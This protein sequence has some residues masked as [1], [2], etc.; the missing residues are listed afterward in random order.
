M[1]VQRIT[2]I[3][4]N[5]TINTFG[6]GA[7]G[8]NSHTFHLDATAVS[9]GTDYTNSSNRNSVMIFIQGTSATQTVLFQGLDA[10]GVV[11]DLVGVKQEDVTFNTFAISTTGKDEC[12][13]I[14]NIFGFTKIRMRIS[15]ITGTAPNNKLTVK[16]VFV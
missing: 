3:L 15:V 5:S 2:E 8:K 6:I 9:N 14:Q 11:Y 10:D 4:E 13:L 7:N 16:G 12:W 1:S